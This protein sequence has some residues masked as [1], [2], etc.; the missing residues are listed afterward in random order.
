MPSQDS[1]PFFEEVGHF[2]R[3][4]QTVG[5]VAYQPLLVSENYSHCPFVWY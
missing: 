3:E 1:N 5:S 2:E 4:F